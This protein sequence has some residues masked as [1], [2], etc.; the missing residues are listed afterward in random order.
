VTIPERVIPRFELAAVLDRGR[1]G[2][3]RR[4]VM[5]LV[6]QFGAVAAVALVGGQVTGALLGNRLL[7]TVFGVLTAVLALRVYAWVVRRTERRP[8][9]E[10]GRAGAVSELLRSTL[11]GI[12]VF[13]A[14]IAVI[15]GFGGYH[16]VGGGS[17]GGA[18]QL[19]GFMAAAAVTEELLFR[20]VL[21]RIIEERTGTW[22]ALAISG[23]AF[24]LIHLLN[25][26]AGPGSALA[27]AVEAGG[28]LGAAYV[29]TRR[30]W[31]P[32]GLHLGWNVAEGGL[33][34]TAVSGKS[35]LSGLV[36]GSVSGPSLFTGGAFGPEASL[37]ALV[38]CLLVSYFLLRSAHRNGRILPRR[39]R[40][41]VVADPAATLPR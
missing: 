8:V 32:I 36:E 21:F 3:G 18:V 38:A 35:E 28:M 2:E 6:K 26:N 9:T 24:G 22:S 31:L 27:I 14:V 39:G 30:L 37:V 41:L 11:L 16:V 5:R 17:L 19:T 33:F 12:G 34:G 10:L 25:P 20:G 29:A 15:A 4:C 1:F 7:S 13:S 23:T 40:R